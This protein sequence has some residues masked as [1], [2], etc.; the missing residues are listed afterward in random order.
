MNDLM[1]TKPVQPLIAPSILAADFASLADDAWASLEAGGDLLHVDIMDGHFVPNLSMG[2]AVVESLRK[3]LP[4]VFL[5]VHL[6][7][8]DPG[9]YFKPFAD[10]GANLLS[11]H[12]EVCESEQHARDLCG[13]I[14]DLGVHTGIVINP[15]TDVERVLPV[16]DAFDLVLVMSVNPGFGGQAFIPEVLDKGRRIAP[17]L[18]DDQRLEID[19]GIGLETA[20]LARQAGFDVLVAGSAVYGK[21]RDQWGEIIRILR[22]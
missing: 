7:V 11:F 15:P 14:G 12:I 22:G 6:M 19:G 18:R 13:V 3:A 9:A 17:L 1:S 16:V 8:S 20:E 4:E 5:D 2:P 10:A 21:P